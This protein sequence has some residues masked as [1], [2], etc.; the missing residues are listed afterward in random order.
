MILPA[1]LFKGAP[2][3]TVLAEALEQVRGTIIDRGP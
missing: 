1:T 2:V 3:W